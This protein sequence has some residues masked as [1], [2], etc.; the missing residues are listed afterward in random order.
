[1]SND[2][3]HRK[4]DELEDNSLNMELWKDFEEAI[5]R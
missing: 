5:G 1:M 2:F 4:K 3:E